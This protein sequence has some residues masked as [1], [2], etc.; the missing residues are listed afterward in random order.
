M[1]WRVGER[2]FSPLSPLTTLSFVASI[3]AVLPLSRFIP[4]LRVNALDGARLS[5][6]TRRCF[7]PKFVQETDN[8]RRIC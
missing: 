7:V 3:Y 1:G 5:V 4:G 8:I 6:H 2:I